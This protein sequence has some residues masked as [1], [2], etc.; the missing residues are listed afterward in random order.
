M[1]AIVA[2]QIEKGCD[3]LSLGKLVSNY[4]T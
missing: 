1:V 3:Q 4:T 2:C